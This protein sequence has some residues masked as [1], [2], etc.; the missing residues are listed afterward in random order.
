MVENL[1]AAGNAL[2]GR[3]VHL[4]TVN[5]YDRLPM[6]DGEIEVEWVPVTHSIP[7]AITRR[8]SIDEAP[9]AFADL[10]AECR[11]VADAVGPA[12]RIRDVGRLDRVER[13]P[14]GR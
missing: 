8:Y 9:Q 4:I 13:V 7:E 6:G 11:R 10:M 12:H 2:T 1:V 14:L 5:D 3:G